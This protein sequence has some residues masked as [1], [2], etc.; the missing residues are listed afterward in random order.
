MVDGVRLYVDRLPA[1]A[2]PPVVTAEKRNI[3]S[4]QVSSPAVGPYA[5]TSFHR[6]PN[7]YDH[8]KQDLYDQHGKMIHKNATGSQLN[9]LI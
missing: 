3:S 1:V 9:T 5:A 2:V 8:S 4:V 7:P 6:H